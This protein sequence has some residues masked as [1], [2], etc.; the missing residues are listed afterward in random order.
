MMN[1]HSHPPEL[2]RSRKAEPMTSDARACEAQWWT[3]EARL[4]ALSDEEFW[5]EMAEASE[6]LGF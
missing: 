3:E 5:A 4:W 6:G 2:E 1:E